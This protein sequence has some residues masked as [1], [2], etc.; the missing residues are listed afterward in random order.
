MKLKITTA[1]IPVAGYGSRMLPVTKAVE[2]YMLPILNRP[3]IDYVV[4]DCIKAGVS[5]IIFVI[6]EGSVQLKEYYGTNNPLEA[7]L[8]NQD[9]SHL[10][11]AVKAPSGVAFTYVEQPKD[12]KYGTAVP[13]A[14]VADL[15]AS[16]QQVLVLMGDDFIYNQDG[17][18]EI[19]RLI[20]SV[21]T[22]QE[23]GL[24]GVPIPQK[25]VAKYGVIQA[26][27]K[28]IFESIV[29]KPNPK[30]A[31]SNLI[32]VSKYILPADLIRSIAGFVK[33]ED[34]KGEYLITE[35]INKW[36]QAGGIMRVHRARGK[37]LDGGNP[38]SWLEANNFVAER[39]L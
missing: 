37:Y 34:L 13:V 35:P 27:K 6:S 16:Q 32:N 30:K 18:S 39:S 12:S 33:N 1:I 20:K 14:L 15:V 19:S 38:K 10:L 23:A 8:K 21:R 28:G 17:S 3:I 26:N 11:P 9:K 24:I 7:Y 2:K 31:P 22:S 5:D 29:E 4:A 36:V 25:D